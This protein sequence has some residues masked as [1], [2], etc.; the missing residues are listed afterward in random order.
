MKPYIIAYI[1]DD[2]CPV[3]GKTLLAD[4]YADAIDAGVKL[5]RELEVNGD[6][7][8]IATDEEIEKQLSA[9][10]YYAPRKVATWSVCIGQTENGD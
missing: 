8:V 3:L 4:T 1:H 10:G 2:G 5:I 9:D 7:L 6:V